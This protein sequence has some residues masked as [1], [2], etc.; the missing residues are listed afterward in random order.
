MRA[1]VPTGGP[2]P[3]HPTAEGT[4]TTRGGGRPAVQDDGLLQQG[5]SLLRREGGHD[6]LRQAQDPRT[7]REP[8]SQGL[9]AQAGKL[10]KP[11]LVI[12]IINFPVPAL[13]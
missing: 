2:R 10:I 1:G 5:S 9:H 11:L 4:A 12:M 13:K 8:I 3:H 6:G 7:R